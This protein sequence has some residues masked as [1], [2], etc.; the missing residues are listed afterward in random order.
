MVLRHAALL[1]LLTLWAATEGEKR[2]VQVSSDGRSGPELDDD[3]S[4][5]A[6]DGKE[7]AARETMVISDD[8]S[9]QLFVAGAETQVTRKE[10]AGESLDI[11]ALEGPAQTQSRLVRQEPAAKPKRAASDLCRGEL[12]P[13][14]CPFE[15]QAEEDGLT[16]ILG[17]G[18]EED[19]C[20]ALTE[21]PESLPGQGSIAFF[22]REAILQGCSGYHRCSRRAPG[23]RQCQYKPGS[24]KDCHS[25]AH[26]LPPCQGAKL[27]EDGQDCSAQSVDDC[28]GNHVV[29]NGMG[30]QCTIKFAGN[31]S[32]SDF[33]EDNHLCGLAPSG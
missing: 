25:G 33:C 29:R 8:A 18:E 30:I 4:A 23:F 14:K 10:D 22:A 16:S 1:C 24:R 7:R 31:P 9:Q 3:M 11:R 26:C 20:E 12:L 21:L 28:D 19:P 17:P 15:Q 27:G 6:E 32:G 13:T 2:A 5:S